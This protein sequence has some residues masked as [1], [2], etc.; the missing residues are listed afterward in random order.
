MNE[1]LTAEELYRKFRLTNNT[2]FEGHISDK[3]CIKAMI[4]FT[5]L[6]V[7]AALEAVATKVV[8]YNADLYIDSSSILESYPEENII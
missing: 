1:I 5:K 2:K 7:K 8:L 4:E 3:D 6:H